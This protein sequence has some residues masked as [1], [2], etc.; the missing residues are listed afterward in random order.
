LVEYPVES[1]D[2]VEGLVLGAGDDSTFLF[3]S[4]LFH[5]SG[6]AGGVLDH[7]ADV[8]VP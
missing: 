3:V 1:V 4:P 2:E 7:L 6:V 5:F 8:G